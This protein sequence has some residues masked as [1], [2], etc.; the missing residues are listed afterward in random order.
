MILKYLRTAIIF[1]ALINLAGCKKFLDAKSDKKLVVISTLQDLQALL[2][3]YG[4]INYSGLDAGELSS[5]DYYLTTADWNSLSNFSERRIHTW[6]KDQLFDRYSNDWSEAYDVVYIANT[7]LEGLNTI[8]RTI[9][10]QEQWDHLKGQAL[11]VRSSAFLDVIGIWTK[12]YD[13]ATAQN[14]LGIPLRLHTDFNKVSER[15][16]LQESYDRILEDLKNAAPVL[17]A[18][19]VYP[20][21]ASKA[22]AFALLARTC[23]WMRDYEKSYRYADS[24]LQLK[25]NLLDFNSSEIVPSAN[26]PI[27]WGNPEIVYIK[28]STGTASLN[29]SRGKIDS[30]LYASYHENDMRKTIFFTPNGNGSYGFKG[31]YSEYHN[32]FTGISVDEVILMYAEAAA[33]KGLTAEAMTALNKLLEKRWKTGT[34]TPLSAGS[35]AEAL[36]IILLERRKELLMRGLRWMDIKRLNKEGANITPKRILSNQV[37]ELPPNDLRYALPLPEVVLQRSGMPQNPR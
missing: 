19:P 4:S 31:S 12:A 26:F 18:T 13:A 33:R 10:N 24:S 36:T 35:P 11:F 21:R 8:P 7:V 14:D 2:D 32:L 16:N 22:S 17:P 20:Y 5:D 28:I 34:F 30:N 27:K 23:L 15:A 29:N 3:N 9:G 6:E 25:N 1:A 37:Y